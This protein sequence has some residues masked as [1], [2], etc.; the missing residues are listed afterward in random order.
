MKNIFIYI[1]LMSSIIFSQTV[2][3]ETLI[4]F[5]TDLD[6]PVNM[7]VDSLGNVFVTCY[8]NGP[9]ESIW[10]ADTLLHAPNTKILKLDPNGNIIENKDFGVLFNDGVKGMCVTN[11][12]YK[13]I[14]SNEIPIYDY[15]YE[16]IPSAWL[17]NVETD[18]IDTLIYPNDEYIGYE[19]IDAKTSNNHPP[20]LKLRNSQ[21][22]DGGWSTEYLTDVDGNIIYE[23]DSL[24]LPDSLVAPKKYFSY[25]YIN[26]YEMTGNDIVTVGS[27]LTT[28]FNGYT[29]I[30]K[31]NGHN[32]IWEIYEE[33]ESF[34]YSTYRFLKVASDIDGDIFINLWIDQDGNQSL[35]DNEYFI[36]KYSSDGSLLFT[37][38]YFS[39]E[40]E[41]IHNI[42]LNQFIA[43]QDGIDQIFKFTDTGSGINIEWAYNLQNTHI[44]RPMDNCFLTTGIIDD[45]LIIRKID[46][47]TGIESHG[48]IPE[49]H[50]LYQNYPNPFN[51]TTEINYTL[52]QSQ[53]VNLS[54]F[55]SKGELVQTLF[56]GKKNQGMHSVK[57]DA[58]KLNSGIYFYKLSTT[59]TA[60]T[61]SMLF[62]K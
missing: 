53:I 4:P 44:A 57:F 1:I 55:N 32:T 3:W 40:F 20:V 35:D 12:G 2:T 21:S 9:N 58:S 46:A 28:L 6:A 52:N 59:K 50:T 17:I 22:L 24:A 33:V 19:F 60:E 62:L 18:I 27:M 38:S 47:T 5:D 14:G 51:P 34:G 16:Y 49:S 37:T 13:L 10:S 56:D 23:L 29:Y 48:S 41:W 7:D 54:V 26:D 39:N 45:N 15:V 8:S 61:K 43:K 30:M 11:N 25:E 31:T 42:G 36:R